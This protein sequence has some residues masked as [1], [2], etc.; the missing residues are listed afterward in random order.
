MF[1][2]Y[3]FG[4]LLLSIRSVRRVGFIDGFLDDIFGRPIGRSARLVAECSSYRGRILCPVPRLQLPSLP[5]AGGLSFVPRGV[6]H[7]G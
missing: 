4:A 6:L 3:S 7:S 2:V 1:H 5:S